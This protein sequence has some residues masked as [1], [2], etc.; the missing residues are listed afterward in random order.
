[1]IVDINDDKKPWLKN[2]IFTLVSQFILIVKK[3]V[4]SFYEIEIHSALRLKS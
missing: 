4:W 2:V 3:L 1:M